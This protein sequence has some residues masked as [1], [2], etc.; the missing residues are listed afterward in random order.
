[1]IFLKLKC[2]DGF[3]CMLQGKPGE[4]KCV[5]VFGESKQTVL[6]M[7]KETPQHQQKIV[8]DPSP[9]PVAPP[10]VPVEQQPAVQQ[11][12][13]I[14]VIPMPNSMPVA[15][16]IDPISRKNNGIFNQQQIMKFMPHLLP[17]GFHLAVAV[18]PQQSESE[19]FQQIQQ[20]E[21]QTH[22]PQQTQQPVQTQ[23]TIPIVQQEVHPMPPMSFNFTAQGVPNSLFE[24]MI[25]P[26]PITKCNVCRK[27]F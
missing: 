16:Q 12:M 13:T 14:P 20:P 7:P 18:K 4:P 25:K 10:T 1:M 19:N 6:P 21:Q 22:Q 27:F 23:Q 15:V 9:S 26:I 2:E 24:P 5:P 11:P 17:Q 3:E 8:Q